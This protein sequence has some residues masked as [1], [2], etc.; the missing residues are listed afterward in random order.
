MKLPAA[1]GLM[2]AG[3]VLLSYSACESPER[4]EPVGTPP[5][6][7]AVS[8]PPV[9]E[10]EE[11]IPLYEPIPFPIR[12]QVGPKTAVMPTGSVLE[13]EHSDPEAVS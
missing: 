4:E 13:D 9:R 8:D 2:V 6:P 1:A 12:I 3:M 5:S 11:L 7:S 10:E